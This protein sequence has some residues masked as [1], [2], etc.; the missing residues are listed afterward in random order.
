MDDFVKT[1]FHP[2][3]AGLLD[4]PAGGGR[5]LFLNA[6]PGF[7]LPEGFAGAIAAVQDFRPAFLAL[8]AAGVSVEPVPQGDGYDLALLL[9]GRHRGQNELWVA[10]ALERVRPGGVVVVA[11][12]KTDGVAS[13]AKRLA[14]LAEVEGR[15][16][17]HHGVVFWLR[18]GDDADAVA[19]ALRPAN[20]AL[21]LDGGFRTLPGLF[22]HEHAD[23]GSR[24]LVDSLPA[25]L[26]GAA[27]DFGAGW[28]YLSAGLAARA[29]DVASIDLFEASFAACEAARANMA[30]LA[31]QVAAQVV[32]RDLLS[33][34]VERRYGLVV[35]NPPFH[36]GRAAEP[37]IG[38]GMIRAAS[39]A[40]KPG[41]RLFLVANR[42]LPYEPVLQQGFARHGETARAARFKVLWAVR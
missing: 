13:L 38:E 29:P 26:K 41:G 15:A 3:E 42:A 34:P 35:M 21:Q 31:P 7:R 40:L 4:L 20:P 16:S 23:P 1:L 2:F 8:K 18:R 5:V 14:G 24:F 19:A 39:K 28:G 22:S 9:L 12:G 11:G 27:A 33:E 10:D 6:A 25:G 17:K 32:W 37:S 30:A 36:Q